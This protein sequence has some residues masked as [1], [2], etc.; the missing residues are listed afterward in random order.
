M[1]R[2]S[3]LRRGDADQRQ[4]EAIL[5]FAADLIDATYPLEKAVEAFEHAQRRGAMKVLVQCRQ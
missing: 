1:T 2:V 5:D 4:V 3:I